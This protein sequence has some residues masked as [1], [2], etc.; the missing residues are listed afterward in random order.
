[1]L[2]DGDSL[3]SLVPEDANHD[4]RVMRNGD[5]QPHKPP[6]L[7]QIPAGEAKAVKASV[8]YNKTALRAVDKFTLRLVLTKKGSKLVSDPFDAVFGEDKAQEKARRE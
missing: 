6:D 1:M 8:T 3:F 7:L 5:I 4:L 2:E